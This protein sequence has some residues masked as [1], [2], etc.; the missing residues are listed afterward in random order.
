MVAALATA[1]L[2]SRKFNI[3]ALMAILGCISICFSGYEAVSL[4]AH[5]LQRKVIL[6]VL[7]VSLAFFFSLGSAMANGLKLV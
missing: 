5:F 4:E 2:R 6:A 1:E 3:I 7:L